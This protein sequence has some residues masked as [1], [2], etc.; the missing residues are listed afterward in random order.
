VLIIIG[1]GPAFEMNMLTP[2]VA[3]S[4]LSVH[5]KIRPCR[6]ILPDF[7]KIFSETKYPTI[8]GLKYPVALF[9]APKHDFMNLM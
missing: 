8:R 4:P 2:S 6:V 3:S 9:S 7:Q 5:V 1:R